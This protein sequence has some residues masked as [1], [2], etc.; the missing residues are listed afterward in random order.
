M[1][2]EIQ[3]ELQSELLSEL[4]S[5]LQSEILPSFEENLLPKVLKIGQNETW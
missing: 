2:S 5:E 4:Q 3:S 1:Q